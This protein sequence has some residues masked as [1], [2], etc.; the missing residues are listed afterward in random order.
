VVITTPTPT[1]KPLAV[2]AAE[3]KKHVFLEKP[4]A[5][6]IADCDVI[7]DAVRLN[8]VFLQLGF[9]R[10]FD[11]EFAAAAQRIQAGEIGRPMMIKSL[12]HGQACPRHG[13][14]T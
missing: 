11:P 2:L 3:H 14:A 4:M 9:M 1:H 5:L 7:I 12:T 6:N 8:G 13:R 10:R